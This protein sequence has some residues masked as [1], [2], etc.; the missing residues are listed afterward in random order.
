MQALSQSPD[1]KHFAY[2]SDSVCTTKLSEAI[3]FFVLHGHA[4]F[5]PS[6]DIGLLAKKLATEMYTQMLLA[7]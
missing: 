6:K 7:Q 4:L 2:T 5:M 3:F 1:Y